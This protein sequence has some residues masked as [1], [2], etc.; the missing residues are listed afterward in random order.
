ML[1][2]RIKLLKLAQWRCCVSIAT[3]I[4]VVEAA[5]AH[6]MIPAA[7]IDWVGYANTWHMCCDCAV[8]VL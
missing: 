5:I 4:G 6:Q 7:V 2:G 3:V 1:Q 8:T